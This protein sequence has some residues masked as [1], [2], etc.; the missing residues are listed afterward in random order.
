M[1]KNIADAWLLGLLVRTSPTCPPASRII[2][3]IAPNDPMMGR[4]RKHIAGTE[5]VIVSGLIRYAHSTPCAAPPSLYA[6]AT[7]IGTPSGYFGY[8]IPPPGAVDFES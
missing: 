1:T 3:I 2:A 8:I 4:A 5:R 6:I 7:S